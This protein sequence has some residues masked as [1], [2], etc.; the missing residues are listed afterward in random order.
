MTARAR[1]AAFVLVCFG[2][3]NQ[4]WARDPANLPPPS[5]PVTSTGPP[6]LLVRRAFRADRNAQTTMS[7][8]TVDGATVFQSSEPPRLEQR[9]VTLYD[10]EVSPG[11][12]HVRA[13]ERVKGTYGFV[14]ASV[15]LPLAIDVHM[16]N[17]GSTCVT[18][19]VYA[20]GDPDSKHP[21]WPSI[22]KELVP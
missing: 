4:T 9:L 17:Q 14:P 2:C 18:Y 13:V 16:P 3:A 21:S 11:L 22:R 6:R 20:G 15:E 12:H 1:A 10:R 7:F 19:T 5:C 8:V